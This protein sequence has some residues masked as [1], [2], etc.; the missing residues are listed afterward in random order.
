MSKIFNYC[1]NYADNFTLSS[2]NILMFGKT[3]LGKTHLSLSIANEVLKKGSN[4]LYD[5]SL[6]YLRII[7]K[8]HFGRDTSGVEATSKCCCLLICLYST[9]LVQN[10][11]PHFIFQPC[12]IL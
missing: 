1:K 10:L 6:N 5:L 2:H 11:I 9:I 4:V 3:G 7:E 8:E 12:I